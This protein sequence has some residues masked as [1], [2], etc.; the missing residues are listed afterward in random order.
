MKINRVDGESRQFEEVRIKRRIESI[1]REDNTRA[2]KWAILN[3]LKI[4][5]VG[6]MYIDLL[7][8]NRVQYLR[9]T[10]EISDII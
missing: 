7:L 6:T 4:S 3:E 10:I 1:Y 9:S 2:I 5:R 8:T